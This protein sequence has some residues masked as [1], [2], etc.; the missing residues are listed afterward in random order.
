MAFEEWVYALGVLAKIIER[1]VLLPRRSCSRRLSLILQSSL[2]SHLLFHLPEPFYHKI[3]EDYEDDHT[4]IEYPLV[5]LGPPLHHPYR[6]PTYPQCGPYAVQPPLCAFQHLSL[7]PQ[8]GQN[9][10]AVVEVTVQLGMSIL[11]KALFP[12]CV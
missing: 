4:P 3:A 5:L 11:H 6:V 8:V 2:P 1:D 12:Q 7:L 9:I 10:S